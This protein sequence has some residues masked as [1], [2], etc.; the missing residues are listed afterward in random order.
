MLRGAPKIIYIF[1][2]GYAVGYTAIV[3]FSDSV[4]NGKMLKIPVNMGF[5][6]VAAMVCDVKNSYSRF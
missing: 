2:I 4:C 3:R 6:G 5:C 1:Y